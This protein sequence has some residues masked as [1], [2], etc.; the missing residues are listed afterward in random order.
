MR[1]SPEIRR[2]LKD[3]LPGMVSSMF[4]KL[5]K[6]RNEVSFTSKG[7]AKIA[8]RSTVMLITVSVVFIVL[9]VPLYTFLAVSG[10][11][12]DLNE[13]TVG[14]LSQ[15]MFLNNGINALLYMFSGSKYRKSAGQILRC[16]S[17][18][19]VRDSYNMASRLDKSHATETNLSNQLE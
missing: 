5:F 7:Q 9:N 10:I 13:A 16:R 3:Q 17:S 4:V 15:L 2:I 6:S 12:E 19:K 1:I 11:A 8:K 14:I 18:N